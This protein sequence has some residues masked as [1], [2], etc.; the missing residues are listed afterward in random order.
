M[1]RDKIN[2]VL[3]K[4]KKQ[5]PKPQKSKVK[6]MKSRRLIE[7]KGFLL[8]EECKRIESNLKE[9]DRLDFLSEGEEQSRIK[10]VIEREKLKGQI[11]ILAW[12]LEMQK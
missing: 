9:F 11:K 1:I 7:E 10:L 8:I 5:E 6:P 2:K 4:Q 3:H 12:V